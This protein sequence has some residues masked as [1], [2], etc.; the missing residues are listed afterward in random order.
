M[1][2]Q[3][4]TVVLLGLLTGLLLGIGFFFGGELGLMIAFIFAMALNFISYWFSDKIV[5]AIYKAKE[6]KLNDNPD[7]HRMIEQISM[8]AKIPK[9]RIYMVKTDT[10]NAFATGR[11]P[12]HAVVSV[13]SGLL[14]LMDE[15]ELR[16][17]L[18]HE[19]SHIK[20]R[21]T[22]ISTIAA[23][24]AGA[25]SMLAFMAR[26]GAIFGGGRARGGQLIGLLVL[27]ILTPIIATIIRLAISRSREFFADKSSAKIIHSSRGLSSALKKLDESV[28][29][30]PLKFGN[31]ATAHMFIVNPFKAS[32]LL[33]FFST[34][35]PVEERIKRLNALKL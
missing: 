18:A 33:K 10:P 25:I 8:M 2:N 20:N 26:W 11:N 13:T 17:V 22:L 4:K 30:N 1:L 12:K 6:V 29:K 9:P 23:T 19:I 5:L 21:D 24:I 16:G 35:P 28:K 7:L 14:K 3:I 15:E 27:G 34:H 31:P 32:T